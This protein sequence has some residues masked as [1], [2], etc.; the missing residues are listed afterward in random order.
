[1]LLNFD[2]N[3]SGLNFAKMQHFSFFWKLLEKG[4]V[5]V[6]KLK[7]VRKF[8]ETSSK[9]KKRNQI[10]SSTQIL[11]CNQRK[12]KRKNICNQG[13]GNLDGPLQVSSQPAA[14]RI[15]GNNMTLSSFPESV[16]SL[17][18]RFSAADGDG[19]TAVDREKH[20][21]ERESRAVHLTQAM[22]FLTQT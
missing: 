19:V 11:F 12:E 14:R 2:Q 21:Q 9:V 16:A 13:E 20:A 1:M 7:I 15:E 5:K 10:L 17:G 4:T 18:A 6:R 8:K 3:F 22:F